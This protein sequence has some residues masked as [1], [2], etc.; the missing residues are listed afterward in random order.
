MMMMETERGNIKH[1]VE[2]ERKKERM[3][4]KKKKKYGR[5]VNR[6]GGAIKNPFG[7]MMIF[8]PFFFKERETCVSFRFLFRQDVCLIFYY[9]G[10]GHPPPSDQ[11]TTWEQD[12]VLFL[13]LPSVHVQESNFFL[14]F[15]SAVLR[16]RRR[17]RRKK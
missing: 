2:E 10:E 4:V 6:G 14:S 16:R 5:G 17:K 13:F 11:V 7:L 1:T 15:R 9:V 3:K 12:K 8:G